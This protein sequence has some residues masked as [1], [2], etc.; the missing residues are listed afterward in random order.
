MKTLILIR[1][2]KAGT[3]DH[4]VPDL[5]RPL[6]DRGKKNILSMGEYLSGSSLNIGHFYTSPAERALSTAR[7]MAPYLGF[8]KKQILIDPALYTFN[9]DDLLLWLRE[10]PKNQQGVILTGHNP[11]LTDLINFLAVKDLEKLP[12]CGIA[13]LKLSVKKW[14]DIVSGS[15]SLT[16]LMY[17]K[18]LEEQATGTA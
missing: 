18:K 10:L 3:G 11:A 16:E 4:G 17:P 2:A 13:V 5:Q 1:H 8:K 7:G 9:S 6:T 12:T 14:Q 15:A